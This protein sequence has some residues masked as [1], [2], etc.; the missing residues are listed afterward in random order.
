[1]QSNNFRD[2]EILNMPPDL[3][4]ITRPEKDKKTKKFTFLVK[5]LGIGVAPMRLSINAETQA[6]AV[7]Y[8]KARWKDCRLELV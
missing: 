7:K 2:K 3:E 5:G 4:G 6:K 1:M 8:I